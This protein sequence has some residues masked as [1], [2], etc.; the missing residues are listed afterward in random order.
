MELNN[1]AGLI[2][3]ELVMVVAFVTR[4]RLPGESIN[5]DKQVVNSQ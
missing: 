5:I 4:V 1:A 3:A 2:A